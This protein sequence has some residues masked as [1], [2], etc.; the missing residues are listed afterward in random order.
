MSERK[1]S[2]KVALM[3][4]ITYTVLFEVAKFILGSYLQYAFSTYRYFYQ[5]YTIIVIIGIWTFYAAL[6]FV[7]TTI[8]ARAYK[9]IYLSNKPSVEQNP[10]TA[11]S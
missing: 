4:S 2:P 3:A 9:D 7:V 1:I 10:Y 5:G 8:F 11:I 6:L